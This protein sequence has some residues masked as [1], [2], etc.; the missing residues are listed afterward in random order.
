MGSGPP[1]MNTRAIG[2]VWWVL[3]RQVGCVVGFVFDNPP[4][5]LAEAHRVRR[6]RWVWWVVFQIPRVEKANFILA[7]T[8]NNP[9]NPP[10]PPRKPRGRSFCRDKQKGTSPANCPPRGPT[11]GARRGRRKLAALPATSNAARGLIRSYRECTT[12]RNLKHGKSQL[13]Q[14]YGSATK[15]SNFS[16]RLWPKCGA[17]R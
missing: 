11:R 2:H 1:R 15:V 10:N 5:Y 8:R 7:S 12:P 9:P 4:D 14:R 17:I 6:I 13:Q 16:T 3:S